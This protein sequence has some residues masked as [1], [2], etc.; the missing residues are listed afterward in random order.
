MSPVSLHAVLWRGTLFTT[1]MS[2]NGE[3]KKKKK[4]SFAVDTLVTN[5]RPR[6]IHTTS[7]WTVVSYSVENGYS[8]GL[9][10]V[11]LFQFSF[12]SL[13]TEGFMHCRTRGE[14]TLRLS[15]HFTKKRVCPS[16][17]TTNLSSESFWLRHSARLWNNSGSFCWTNPDRGQ[18]CCEN[19][20]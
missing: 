17:S 19:C 16:L 12:N 8:I 4:F 2:T 9:P 13:S 11:N 20:Q 18:T 3:K 10:Y 15:I 1:A 5:Q 6:Q 14:V 7:V